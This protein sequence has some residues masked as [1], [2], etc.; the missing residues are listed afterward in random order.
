MNNILTIINLSYVVAAALFI[1]GLKLLS[2]PDTARKGNFVSAVGM[3][4]AVLIT[5]L[6]QQIISYHYI[7]LGFVIGGA[8]GVWK[9]RTIEMTAM[10]EMVSLLNGFGGLASLVLGW[11]TLAGMDLST[12]QTESTFVFVTLFFTILVGGI[13]FSGSVVAWGKLSGKLSSKAF[14]FKGLR[15]L[16]VL[17]LV[18]MLVVGYLF[19][20]APAT[21]LWLYFAIALS[22]SFGLWATISIGGADMP[23]VIAQIGRAHV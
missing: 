7:L 10:P 6:D 14:V 17:H 4:V 1:I 8:F 13:T 19:V 12:L 3:L 23:V 18:A 16:S 22:L 9:A 15:E 21:H 2:H 20:T 11:A 5:L